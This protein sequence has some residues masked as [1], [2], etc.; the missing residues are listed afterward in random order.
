MCVCVSKCNVNAHNLSELLAFYGTNFKRQ[1]KPFAFTIRFE[2]GRALHRIIQTDQPTN[3][4]IDKNIFRAKCQQTSA[5]CTRR[6]MVVEYIFFCLW[7]IIIIHNCEWLRSSENY[8]L[9]A[10][11]TNQAGSPTKTIERTRKKNQR[12]KEKRKEKKKKK[13]STN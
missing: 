7:F 10:D 1:E 5:K 11:W 3:R 8:F 4:P 2:Y 12:E 6:M 9:C 13:T